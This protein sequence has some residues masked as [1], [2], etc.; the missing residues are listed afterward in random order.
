[1]IVKIIGIAFIVFGL[2]DLI[3]SFVGFDVWTDFL[4]VNLPEIIWRFSAY[5]EL[6][7]GYFLFKIG[8]NKA[9]D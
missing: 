5:I 6:A 3:G 4:R 2:V 1:M 9:E 7:L 8:S